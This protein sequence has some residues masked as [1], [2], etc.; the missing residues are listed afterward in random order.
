MDGEAL[1]HAIQSDPRLASTR[2]VMLTSIGVHNMQH[3]RQA[4]FFCCADKPVRREELCRILCDALSGVP[5]LPGGSCSASEAAATAARLARLGSLAPLS[6]RILLAEDNLTNQ[7]VALG[8]LKKMGLRAD[9]V[10]DGG[11]A[12]KSLQ[13]IPY[14]LVLMDMRMPVMDGIEATRRI[15]GPQSSALN[16][17]IPIIAM[18]ANVQ[19]TDRA[20]CLEAGMNGF[21]PKPVSPAAVR[22][23]LE[24]WLPKLPGKASPPAINVPSSPDAASVPVF[25]RAAVLERAMGDQRLAADILNS[26][27]EETPRQIQKLRALLEEGQAQTCGQQ[28]HSI[29]GA[30]ANIGGERLRQVAWEMEKAGD[31]GDLEAIADRMDSLESRFLELRAEAVLL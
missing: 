4:G 17:Q 6:G 5:G 21:I 14:D 24:E 28:A 30:A 1:G 10:G 29:K 27:L 26:F 9:A 13:T 7:L 15:R 3:S 11:E 31:A 19:Q 16:R 12:V 2:M 22:A 25:D 8:I 18:T 23:A 20:A